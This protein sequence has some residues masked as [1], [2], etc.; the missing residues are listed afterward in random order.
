MPER[1]TSREDLLALIADRL[2]NLSRAY[3]SPMTEKRARAYA[4]GVLR[5][6]RAAGLKI[7]RKRDGQ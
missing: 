7:S 2:M 3:G 4:D 5:A 1:I 6:M